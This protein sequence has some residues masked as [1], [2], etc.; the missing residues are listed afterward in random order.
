MPE[1]GLEGKE[2]AEKAFKRKA[3]EEIGCE[4]EII[5]NLGITEEYKSLNNFKQILYKCLPFSFVNDTIFTNE[6]GKGG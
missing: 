3:L 4:V 6:N 1:G 2:E 5:Q